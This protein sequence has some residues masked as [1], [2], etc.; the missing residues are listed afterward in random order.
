[1]IE[2]KALNLLLKNVWWKGEKERERDVVSRDKR[3][4]DDFLSSI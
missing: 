4:L 2:I 1:M 3:F